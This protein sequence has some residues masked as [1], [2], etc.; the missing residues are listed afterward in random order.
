MT[1]FPVRRLARSAELPWWSD[2]RRSQRATGG[3]FLGAALF[4]DAR[5]QEEL[6]PPNTAAHRTRAHPPYTL[7]PALRI[8]KSKELLGFLRLTDLQEGRQHA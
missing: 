1:A 8:G 5:I 6:M 7:L 2:D 3:R 4:Q